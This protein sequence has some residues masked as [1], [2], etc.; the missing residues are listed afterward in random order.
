MVKYYD[1]T[2]VLQM[3]RTFVVI[4][5]EEMEYLDGGGGVNK[6]ET[7]FLNVKAYMSTTLVNQIRGALG[8]GAAVCGIASI[9]TSF[10]GPKGAAAALVLKLAAYVMG[11]GAGYL[12]AMNAAGRGLIVELSVSLNPLKVYSQ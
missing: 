6:V 3:P 1:G 4:E 7:S 11:L 12:T 10:L 2:A 5:N 8:M 9:V